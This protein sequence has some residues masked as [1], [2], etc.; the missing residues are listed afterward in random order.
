MLYDI[1]EHP[2]FSAIQYDMLGFSGQANQIFND[3]IGRG[4]ADAETAKYHQRKMHRRIIRQ[5]SP[6]TKWHAIFNY[7]IDLATDSVFG[8]G[9]YWGLLFDDFL[10]ANECEIVV[11]TSRT[12]S[13]DKMLLCMPQRDQTTIDFC[14]Q[15]FYQG[16]SL[17]VLTGDEWYRWEQD[18]CAEILKYADLFINTYFSLHFKDQGRVV[19]I[20]AG[21][22]TPEYVNHS[23]TI[24]PKLAQERKYSWAFVGDVKKSTR[25]QM[26]TNMSRINGGYNHLISGW[27]ASDSL[28]PQSYR[29]IMNDS[30]FAPCP[31]GWA[32][33]DS[34]RVWESLEAGCIP[35][36]EKRQ[37]YDYFQMVAGDHP[38]VTVES[39]DN[40]HEV[41]LAIGDLQDIEARRVQCYDWWMGYKRE[42]TSKIDEATRGL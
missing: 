26:I 16:T 13:A 18:F 41:L 20:P 2:L 17:I 27:Q 30:I 7:Q 6:N 40:I 39:W 25:Q 9:T 34:Y 1:N 14:K 38:M 23:R 29:D 5:A 15:A 4:G 11:D 19:Q 8:P 28:S 22:M 31:A 36:V 3:I 32:N 35:I 10:K 33:L 37:Y 24:R 21:W 42:L 12:F